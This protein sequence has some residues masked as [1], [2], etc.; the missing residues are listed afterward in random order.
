MITRKQIARVHLIFWAVLLSIICLEIIPDLGEYTVDV[1]VTTFI[2]YVGSF[3]LFFYFGYFSVK[4]KHLTKSVIPVIAVRLAVL[5]AAAIPLSIVYVL[6]F[7]ADALKGQINS[8]VRVLVIYYLSFVEFDFLFAAGGGILKAAIL[9]YGE[10]MKSKESEKRAAATELA[11][12]KSQINPD[13][14]FGTLTEI[15]KLVKDNKEKAISGIENLAE[16]MSYMLYET[17]ADSVK[18]GDEIKCIRHLLNLRGMNLSPGKAELIVTGDTAGA[19]I[20]PLV[21]LPFLEE[22]LKN[23]GRENDGDGILIEISAGE[24]VTEVN[25]EC[26]RANSSKGSDCSEKIKRI[27]EL[28]YGDNYELESSEK[29]DIMK[30]TLRLKQILS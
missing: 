12:L 6:L 8:D 9:W 2:S 11:L 16:I 14:L 21:L 20:A 27:L 25:V 30:T 18:L 29:P 28:Q 22:T 3:I 4:Q 5:L 24:S 1:I 26:P 7:Q 10:V 19:E 17:K 23:C 15:E 13:F